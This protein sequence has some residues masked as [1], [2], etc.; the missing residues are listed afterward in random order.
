MSDVRIRTA[1]VIEEVLG[2]RT[3]RAVLRNGKRILA[4]VQPLDR[5]E[6]LRQGETCHV[7]LSL[8]NFNEGR[9]VPKDMTTVRV[10][11]PVIDCF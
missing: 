3:C 10:S 9:I 2:E 1:A 6:D 8:C 5:R 11:H 4:Y 7:L